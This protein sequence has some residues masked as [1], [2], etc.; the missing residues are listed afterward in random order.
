[1]DLMDIAVAKALS[2]G[3]G[4]SAENFIV[5]FSVAEDLITADKTFAQLKDAFDNKQGV[6]G[7]MDIGDGYYCFRISEIGDDYAVLLAVELGSSS[8][9]TQEILIYELEWGDNN[10]IT[11][12]GFSSD[13]NK[14]L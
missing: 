14:E 3:G 11:L 5:A 8:P 12:N 6:L 1:M 13:F 9:S 7:I 10:D 2:G 4:G